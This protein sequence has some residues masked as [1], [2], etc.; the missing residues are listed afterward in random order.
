M[1]TVVEPRIKD[2]VVRAVD[3]GLLAEAPSRAYNPTLL[4]KMLDAVLQLRI[5]YPEY[6]NFAGNVNM[7]DLLNAMAEC[8]EKQTAITDKMRSDLWRIAQ[9]LVED[10]DSLQVQI[11]IGEIKLERI[12]EV[13]DAEVSPK[14]RA[15]FE[16]AFRKVTSLILED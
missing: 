5:E 15:R 8:I 14:T 3:L 10:L 6:E 11:A 13:M 12:M 4:G 2:R 9:I 1:S 16:R 7:R